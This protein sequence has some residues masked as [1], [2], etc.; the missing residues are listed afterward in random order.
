MANTFVKYTGDGVTNTYSIPFGYISASHVKVLVAGV[1]VAFT[2]N[3]SSTALLAAAPT[4]GLLIVIKRVTPS[5]PLV[6]FTDGSTLFEYDLDL[7]A[8]QNRYIAEEATDTANEALILDGADNKY[9]ADSKVIKNLANPVNAQDAATKYYLENTWLSAADKAQL[10]ALD[11]T[12][13]HGV[14]DDLADV[15]TVADDLNGPDTIGIVYTSITN[16][17]TVGN[18]IASVGVNATNI[19]SINTNAANII[20]IQN[21]EENA[22][23]ALSSKNAAATSETNAAA[24]ATNAA[25]SA[26]NAA[27]SASGAA[28]QATTAT[29]Q[30]GIATSQASTATTQAGIATTQALTATTQAGVATTKASEASSSASNAASSASG[31]ST[32]QAAALASKNAAA[33]SE[34]NAATSETNAATSAS[35]AAS[36]ETAAA[37]SSSTASTQAG[38]ATTQAGI[39]TTKAGEAATSAANALTSENNAASSESAASGSASAAASSAS[40]ASGSATAAAGSATSALASADAALAALDNF[41]DRYLG[42]KASAPTVDND[43]NALLTGSLY[44]DTGDGS[45]KVYEGS[46]WVAAY[47]SLSGA[48]I[49]TNNLIDLTNTTSA[50]TNLGLSTVAS[51]GSYNDLSGKPTLGTAAATAATAY[52]TAAQGALADTATQPSD[53][54]AVAVSGSY[55]DLSNLPILT[56]ITLDTIVVNDSLKIPAGTTAQRVVSPTNGNLRYNTTFGNL[57][58]FSDTAWASLSAPPIVS[59]VSPLICGISTDTVFT[60]TGTS[61]KTG[62]VARF[63]PSTGNPITAKSTTVVSTTT[64][65]C[66]SPDNLDSFA[67]PYAIEIAIPSGLTNKSEFVIEVDAPPV[68]STPAG[69]I[70]TTPWNVPISYSIVATDVEGS[71]TYAL[72]SGALPSGITLNTSTGLL[73][74]TLLAQETTTYTFEITAID[75]FTNSS[76][77]EFNI[78]VQNTAPIWQTDPTIPQSTKLDVISI[79]LIANDPEGSTVTYSFISGALP[80]GIS[81]SGNTLT[82]TV[83]GTAAYAPYSFTVRASDSVL[84]TDQTFSWLLAYT[85]PIPFVPDF[86][87]PSFESTVSGSWSKPANLRNKAMVWVYHVGGGGGGNSNRSYNGGWNFGGQGGNATI[88]C[89]TAEYLNGFSWTI[90]AGGGPTGGWQ[91]GDHQRGY[92]N[93]QGVNYATDT[94]NRKISLGIT[95]MEGSAQNAYYNV[96]GSTAT[97]TDLGSYTGD[98]E[99]YGQ[100]GTVSP[101]PGTMLFAGGHGFANYSGGNSRGDSI[102]AGGGAYGQSGQGLPFGGGGGGDS[103]SGYQGRIRIYYGT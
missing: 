20:D 18:N 66:V 22:A 98:A 11:T 31:A 13:L 73:S 91:G 32:S 65:T 99:R 68:F 46:G 84:Y 1:E 8:Q 67:A 42:Q 88:F 4:A 47:A 39:S 14:Y 102:F 38:I 3:N 6:D 61:F 78:V 59:N 52:A 45:M 63:I 62:S 97:L 5:A 85:G 53:L 96:N 76:S 33:I 82:G 69:T 74:G 83:D 41:D 72:T 87:S 79:P 30:A 7:S 40:A 57:E 44:F 21:A 56:D 55:G 34:T 103:G 86:A 26:T 64:I 60:I 28:T 90:A 54:A 27:S 15:T 2:F 81:L 101:G 24:S 16:V 23:S 12:K 50:K 17:N 93:I 71:V 9:D 51:S 49:A 25:A 100:S 43:G 95:S 48:L 37:G 77:R 36:S 19:A 94:S 10:N 35:N 80:V 89:T 29:T 70:V 92:T 58:I 75:T